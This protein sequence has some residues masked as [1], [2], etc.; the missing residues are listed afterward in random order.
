MP[1]EGFTPAQ[2]LVLVEHELLLFAGLF[3]LLG[4]LDELAV[5][6][7]W[8][9]LRITGRGK[10]ER[11][12]ADQEQLPLS[13][14][15]AVFIPAWR[16]EAVIEA[17]V[18]HAL[19]AWPQADLRLYVGCY[20]N[21]P[22]TARAARAGADGDGRL[23]VVIMSH[24]GPTTKADCLNG[25]YRALQDEERSSGVPFHMVVLHDAEDMVDPAAL[26]LLDRHIGAADLV[27][28][29]VLPH[30]MPQSRWIASH[31]CE[32]F[33]EQHGKG[34]VVRDALGAGLPTAGVGCAIARHALMTLDSRSAGEGPFAAEC[35]TED[36]ELGLG[37]SALGGNARFV[38]CRTASGRLVATR[39]CF[40]AKLEAAVR[41]KTRW[42]HGIAFQSWYRLGW[43]RNPADLWMRLRD[44]R[45]PLTA[46]VLLIA[47][48]LLFLVSAGWIAQLAGFAPEAD[49]SPA[50]LVL[51]AINLA[52]F[53]WRAAWRFAFTAREYGAAEG[54][55]AILRIPVTNVISIMAGR[56]AFVAYVASLG[57]RNPR[58]DKTE[59]IVHPALAAPHREA[60]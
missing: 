33:A 24:P 11:L 56:R 36:Y 35:L 45:G 60:A 46:L 18:R 48:L 31:Y 21:D 29:P 15:A 17:T 38:R 37:V 25:L 42:V 59:H 43:S 44:R 34:M 20:L 55:R 12:M 26:S 2:W 52:S 13:G 14:R 49:L 30:P 19:D 16:E 53:A 27:Q 41:Q 58:W 50:L 8:V 9:W 5:D 22:A 28:L 1:G 10:S 57:G 54:L 47:Y 32:E 7:I 23:R 4:A 39:A 51:L 3:F 40:P 6:L